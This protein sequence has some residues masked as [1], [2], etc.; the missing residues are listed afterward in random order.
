MRTCECSDPGC[1]VHPG[2]DCTKRATVEMR[3]IDFAG[4]PGCEFCAECAGDA[5]DSGVFAYRW[6][7]EP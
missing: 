6:E 7:F 1:P 3:R 2:A 4:T 5:A